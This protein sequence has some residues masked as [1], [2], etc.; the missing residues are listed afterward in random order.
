MDCE[1]NALVTCIRS[2]KDRRHFRPACLAQPDAVGLHPERVA[3]ERRHRDR[4]DPLR[5]F[6]GD[7]LYPVGDRHLKLRR[8]FDRDDTFVALQYTPAGVEEGRFARGGT[9]GD[10]DV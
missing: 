6:A 7:E 5:R 3:H 4:V 9:T 2:G 8:V 1:L 10:D